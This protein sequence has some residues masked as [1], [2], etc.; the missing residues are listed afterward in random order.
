MTAGRTAWQL[1]RILALLVLLRATGWA[2]A[3]TV[4]A[5]A[6]MDLD[7]AVR[8][9]VALSLVSL[10]FVG[11]M[12]VGR[13]RWHP[14]AVLVVEAVIAA[15]LALVPP[16]LWVIWFGVGGWTNTM[17]GG[18]VQPLAVAWL[19][20]VVLRGSQQLRDADRKTETPD[21]SDRS[22]RVTSA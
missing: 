4:R 5:V 12:L 15:V 8:S 3:P 9:S 21:G 22:S 13:R 7:T 14:W 18:P 11:V 2:V 1:A 10:L 19:G 20:V 16:L 6:A 17:V